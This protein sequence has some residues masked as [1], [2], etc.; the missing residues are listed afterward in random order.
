MSF[1]EITIIGFLGADPEVKYTKSNT[2]VL[3]ISVG[4]SE[5][6][7]AT[8]PK[9]IKAK[10]YWHKCR[11]WGKQA[12]NNQT[13][14]ENPQGSNSGSG[15][16]GASSVATSKHAGGLAVYQKH[17]RLLTVDGALAYIMSMDVDVNAGVCWLKD[18]QVCRFDTSLFIQAFHLDDLD[19]LASHSLHDNTCCYACAC[20]Y[21]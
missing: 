11:R 19:T 9:D 16:G 18:L 17:E 20:V 3:T 13:P 10:T 5:R 14:N 2:A 12:E 8:A 1:S 21:L 4:V 6:L 7:K 15:N